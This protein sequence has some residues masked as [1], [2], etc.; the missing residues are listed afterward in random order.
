[1]NPTEPEDAL[2]NCPIVSII[3]ADA[4]CL[5]VVPNMPKIGFAK[6]IS[7]INTGSER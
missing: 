3:S 7:I 6:R 2:M 4:P 1:M 5:N